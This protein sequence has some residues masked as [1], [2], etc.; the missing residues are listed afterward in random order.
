MLDAILTMVSLRYGGQEIQATLNMKGQTGKVGIGS[1]SQQLNGDTGFSLRVPESASSKQ[2]PQESE[3]YTTDQAT[4]QNSIFTE[5]QPDIISV[6]VSEN[7]SRAEDKMQLS[8]LSY[9]HEPNEL[10]RMGFLSA[11]VIFLHNIPEGLATFVTTIADPHAGAAVAFA[12][13]LHN[14]PEASQT[15]TVGPT[16]PTL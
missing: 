4:A 2:R 6:S 14:I 8:S 13:A 16:R 9:V 7:D 1:L 3:A 15:R 12:V 11:V 10:L 5:A